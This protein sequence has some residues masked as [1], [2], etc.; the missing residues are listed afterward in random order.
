LVQRRDKAEDNADMNKGD[1]NKAACLAAG[2]L[3]ADIQMIWTFH[4]LHSKTET[5]S[6]NRPDKLFETKLPKKPSDP[7]RR[8]LRGALQLL[9]KQSVILL[10]RGITSAAQAGSELMSS[11]YDGL[12]GRG[13]GVGA[14]RD[15]LFRIC[16]IQRIAM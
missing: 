12:S 6:R 15:Q 11:P 2:A 14:C 9:L 5:G 13:L 16:S 10:A 7:T 3:V 8:R 4:A 1:D